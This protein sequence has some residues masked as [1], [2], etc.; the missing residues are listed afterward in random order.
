[1][2]KQS[3][4]TKKKRISLKYSLNNSDYNKYIQRRKKNKLSKKNKKK[5]EKELSK[6]YIK[7]VNKLKK[8]NLKKTK[9]RRSKKSKNNY[10]Y[11]ICTSAIY[12]SRGFKRPKNVIK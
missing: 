12:N 5:L 10:A 8:S 1:M 6:R 11:A 2:P 7:C 3:K 4:K 9:K